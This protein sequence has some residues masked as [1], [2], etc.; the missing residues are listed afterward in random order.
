MRIGHPVVASA[1]VFIGSFCTLV[2]EL[3]AGRIMA[4]Y[5]GVSLYTWTSIIGV[6]LAGIS[7]GNYAG[8][9]LA[10]RMASRGV[11]GALFIV[12][13]VVSLA[14]LPLTGFII[15]LNL[16]RTWPLMVR[17]VVYT[18]LIFFAPTFVLGMI[19]PLVIKL[20]LSDLNRT[21][22]IVG[23]IYAFSTVGSI[24]GTFATG[25]YLVEAMGTRQI[26]WTVSAVLILVGL[27]I[28]Q[29]WRGVARGATAILLVGAFAAFYQMRADFAGP[30][31]RESSY[32]CI[33]VSTA[34]VEGVEVSSLVLDHLVHSYVSLDNP[35]FIGYGYERVYNE[36]TEW[37]AAQRPRFATLSIGGGGYTFPKFVA[38]QYPFSEVDVLEIDPAVTTAAHDFL[39]L[40]RDGR[41][42]THNQDARIWYIE[43]RPINQFDL[44]YGDAFNDISVPYHLT[45]LEFDQM[46][47]ASMRSDGIL[48]TNIIDNYH[49]GDFLRAYL[50]TLD[51]VFGNVYLFGVG[52]AWEGSGPSTYVAVASPEPLDIASFERF[53][54]LMTTRAKYSAILDAATLRQYLA[55]GRQI[56]LTDDYAPVDNLVA[57]LF[58][59]RGY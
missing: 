32:Y 11:L 47:K 59:E 50:K 14:I 38:A 39:G 17:I 29:Y 18:G 26:V 5:I 55:Q 33:R 54:G 36:I 35:K 21:G 25:F 19:S 46:V 16:D 22:S 58:V 40:P 51:K 13:G 28:G 1:I 57:R 2:I 41:I 27:M 37:H 9:W 15:N 10:D 53:E 24:G 31:L 43:N 56:I 12:A 20:S 45:T 23:R 6:T 8:G 4:P 48:M 30:C 34:I 3:I 42:R 44:V 52:R 49:S 7:F